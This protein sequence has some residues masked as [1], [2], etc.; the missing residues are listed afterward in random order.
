MSLR[1]RINGELLCAAKHPEENDDTYID[2]RLHGLL[3]DLEVVIPENDEENTGQWIWV[4]N[5]FLR[6]VVAMVK[7]WQQRKCP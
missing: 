6:S 7:N 3:A 4:D 2:D 5:S 1:W